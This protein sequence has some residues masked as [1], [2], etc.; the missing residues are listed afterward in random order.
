[1]LAG[2]RLRR[3]QLISL[4]LLVLSQLR[5]MTRNQ[6]P[7]D[8][9]EGIPIHRGDH[10]IDDQVPARA[11]EVQHHHNTTSPGRVRSGLSPFFST[12]IELLRV[13][14][15]A[16]SSMATMTAT[17]PACNRPKRKGDGGMVRYYRTGG[18]YSHSTSTSRCCASYGVLGCACCVLQGVSIDQGLFRELSMSVSHCCACV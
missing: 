8:R 17:K 5:H 3:L 13:G 9:G 11:I 2:D 10:S 7:R 16:I 18:G 12:T 4:E 1:M 15:P 6:R 14:I